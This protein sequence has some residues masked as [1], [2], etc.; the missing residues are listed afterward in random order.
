[1]G[2]AR[3][4]GTALSLLV[5]GTDYW[6]DATSV[7]L[8]GEDRAFDLL[9]GGSTSVRVR[10]WL[11]VEAVQSTAQGSLWRLL[12]EH[13]GRALPFAYAPHGNSRPS[14]DQPHFTG[15]LT[16]PDVPPRLGGSAGRKVEQKFTTRLFIS[17]G[18][19]RVTTT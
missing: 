14:E 12:W 4:P 16:L 7:V 1:M 2:S 5:D 17:Q 19:L 3:I 10:S 11:D 6:A 13:P 9:D 8:D 18:P 15:I